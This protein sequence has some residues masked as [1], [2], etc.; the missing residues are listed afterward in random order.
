M[1]PN[2]PDAPH[3]APL[4]PP[5]PPLPFLP[6]FDPSVPPPGYVPPLQLQHQATVES[7]LARVAAELKAI[8]RKDI[9]RRMVEGVAFQAFDLWWEEKVK[10]TK[11]SA[12]VAKPPVSSRE[13]AMT[14][15]DAV[16]RQDV[17]ALG[18]VLGLGALRLPSFKVKRKKRPGVT[19]E[20]QTKR[21]C[22]SLSEEE[23][24]EP[25]RADMR[26]ESTDVREESAAAG[27]LEPLALDS[28][29]EEDER[30]EDSGKVE[31]CPAVSE[32]EVDRRELGSF[33]KYGDDDDDDDDEGENTEVR[34]SPPNREKDKHPDYE[35]ISLSS[36]SSY[37]DNTSTSISSDYISSSTD[38]TDSSMWSGGAVH[39]LEG[40][41]EREEEEEEMEEEE[42]EEEE[43]EAWLSSSNRE[44]TGSAGVHVVPS[45]WSPWE[46]E[47]P[48]PT[49]RAPASTDERLEQRL[50]QALLA[51]EDIRL[52]EDH[53]D[54]D[55][56]QLRACLEGVAIPD[57]A[58]CLS[59]GE[60]TCPLSPS[61]G[62]VSEDLDTGSELDAVTLET[63]EDCG[64]LRP[65][66]PTGS[67][68]DSDA[69]DL[70]LSPPAALEERESPTPLARLDTAEGLGGSPS[71]PVPTPLPSSYPLYEDI[72]RTPGNYSSSVQRS[73]RPS[74][75]LTPDQGLAV[76]PASLPP[77]PARGRPRPWAESPGSLPHPASAFEF[78]EYRMHLREPWHGD[79]LASEPIRP[80]V[81]RLPWPAMGPAIQRALRRC[82]PRTSPPWGENRPTLEELESVGLVRLYPRHR[83]GRGH[84]K[85]RRR[86]GDRSPSRLRL[87]RRSHREE[88]SALHAVWRSGVDDQEIGHLKRSYESMKLLRLG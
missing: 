87:C 52:D 72:P 17:V 11:A 50:E 45:P 29:A 21:T 47:R 82:T 40:A 24:A 5:W 73:R 23:E 61:Y 46:M 27:I 70:Q 83:A 75:A 48:P 2:S 30:E 80:G 25:E 58:L 59:P 1:R 60:L 88:R 15:E 10:S 14:R 68:S 8:V 55:H 84:I 49:P 74:A 85:R 34:R 56:L 35:V 71:Y 81:P 6:R 16:A 38:S 62:E 67:V 20:P 57:P 3:P 19:S 51:C 9:L 28:E 33:S 79:H 31:D 41:A 32:D 39:L 4:R 86:R 65:P 53:L 54:E 64:T 42:E 77:H 37:Y 12:P 78:S 18:V 26:E 22:P 36:S 43:R 44:G 76:C 7:V 13:D 63:L 66:T 69:S